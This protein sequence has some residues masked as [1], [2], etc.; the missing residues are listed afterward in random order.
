[1]MSKKL[2][3][4]ALVAPLGLLPVAADASFYTGNELYKVCSADRGSKEYVERTYECIAYITGAIDAFNTTRKV[5]KLNSCIPA[6]VT[7]SQLR[8]VTV[9]Y[10]EDHPKG[11]GASASELVFAATRNEWPCSKKKK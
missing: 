3:C 11:R 4:L 1:M 6:D 5:N 7:I 9:D 8:T 2:A 10:L